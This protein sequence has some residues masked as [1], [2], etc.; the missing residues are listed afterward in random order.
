M[1]CSTGPNSKCQVVNNQA[2][3][4]CQ[5]EM[6]G[7]APNCRPECIRNSDCPS[8]LACNN[9]KCKD[10]CP[11][12]CGANTHCRV[13]GHNPVCSCKESYTGDPFRNCVPIRRNNVFK[14]SLCLTYLKIYFLIFGVCSC[15]IRAS[16]ETDTYPL[17]SITLWCQRCLS[18][19]IGIGNLSMLA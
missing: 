19:T 1:I 9:Q 15:C 12:V 18:R 16:E 7:T 11:G 4:G 14:I 17:Q 13:V 2:Q 10:P 5:D 3:C 8:N 6:I